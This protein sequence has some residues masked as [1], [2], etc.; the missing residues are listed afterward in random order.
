MGLTDA[1]FVGKIDFFVDAGGCWIW[2]GSKNKYGYGFFSIGSRA[3][4]TRKRVL[5]HRYAYE[6]AYGD[7]GKLH[8][9]H[10]CDNPGCCNPAHLWAGTHQENIA[11]RDAKGRTFRGTRRK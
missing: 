11:D 1:K 9:C 7:I 5:A 3:D 6:Q 2:R 4:G 8:V 10:R